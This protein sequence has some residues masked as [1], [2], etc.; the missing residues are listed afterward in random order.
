M[1][2]LPSPSSIAVLPTPEVGHDPDFPCREIT[3]LQQEKVAVREQAGTSLVPVEEA[4]NKGI[5]E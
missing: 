2:N 5:K 1:Q 4:K 3:S